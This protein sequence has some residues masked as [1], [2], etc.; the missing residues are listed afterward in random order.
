MSYIPHEWTKGE[1]ITAEKLNHMENGI[2]SA[3]SS[4]GEGGDDNLFIVNLSLNENFTEATK[5]K[6]IAEIQEAI[7]DGKFVV[8]VDSE[9]GAQFGLVPEVISEQLTFATRA[10][11]EDESDEH[12]GVILEL[13]VSFENDNGGVVAAHELHTDNGIKPIGN[14]NSLPN[15]RATFYQIRNLNVFGCVTGTLT[16]G[17]ISNPIIVATNLPYPLAG[18]VRG[19]TEAW[20]VANN[21]QYYEGYEVVWSIQSQVVGDTVYGQLEVFLTETI[22]NPPAMNGCNFYF[23]FMY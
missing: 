14:V 12:H 18:A 15:I 10:T 17:D 22:V 5:D 3:N 21:N 7:S 20:F 6:T 11:M 19:K 13:S 2:E 9:L 8:G 16:T 4:G 23:T 1:V